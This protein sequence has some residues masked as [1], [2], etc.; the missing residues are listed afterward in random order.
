MA[1]GDVETV[2]LLTSQESG[3]SANIIS[4]LS[5]ASILSTDRLVVIPASSGNGIMIY[6]LGV[7]AA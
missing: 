6:K 4:D 1:A 7:A 5:G 3:D 2:T